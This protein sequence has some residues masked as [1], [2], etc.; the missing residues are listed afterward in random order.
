MMSPL[1][2]RGDIF[3]EFFCRWYRTIGRKRRYARKLIFNFRFPAFFSSSPLSAFGSSRRTDGR[4]DRC[5]H[6]RNHATYN[7]YMCRIIFALHLCVSSMK[8]TT[9]MFLS[10]CDGKRKPDITILAKMWFS[11]LHNLKIYKIKKNV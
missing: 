8:R 4:N 9:K 2:Y 3:S 5:F 6:N 7:N 11:I 1:Q 10:Y